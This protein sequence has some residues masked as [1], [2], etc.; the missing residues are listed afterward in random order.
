M[1][2][3]TERGVLLLLLKRTKRFKY[4]L[5]FHANMNRKQLELENKFLIS[6]IIGSTDSNIKKI[7]DIYYISNEIE[8]RGIL[9]KI[10]SH[11]GENYG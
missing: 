8:T 10:L 9:S 1:Y 2:I 11:H 5:G 3:G 4:L 6:L 7:Y